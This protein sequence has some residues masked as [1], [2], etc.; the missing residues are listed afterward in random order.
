MCQRGH[1]SGDRQFVSQI[2]AG[3]AQECR[4]GV[5]WGGQPRRPDYRG[6]SARFQKCELIEPAD[7]I[8]YTNPLIELDQVR[9]AP[10]QHMLAVINYFAS[11]GVLI[12]R[13]T[14]AQIRTTLEQ[15]DVEAAVGKNQP[16][17]NP[18]KP[19]PTTATR[20]E[21]VERWFIIP[22]A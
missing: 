10:E 20:A 2:Q 14:S 7:F 12:G 13:S 16:A 4:R 9:A 17:A 6:T 21:C 11:A 3:C 1:R 18:A 5:K 22:S 19:L 15:S 8:F